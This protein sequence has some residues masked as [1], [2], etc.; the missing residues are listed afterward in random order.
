MGT[1]LG[2][3]ILQEEIGRGAMSVIHRGH[4]PH[5]RRTLAIKVLREEFASRE[6]YR[7][8]FLSEARAAGT[9]THPG[10]VTLF[11]IGESEGVPFI[12][13]E[14]LD[15][16]T[17]DGFVERDGPLPTRMVLRIVMQLADA[18]DYAHRRGVVHQ[19]I[20]PE[21]IAVI[22][23]NGDVKLMDFG[24]ARLRDEATG[25]AS[26]IVAGTPQ[27]MSPEQIRNQRVD[28]RSDLYSLGVLLY[29]LLTGEEPFRADN[30]KELFRKIIDDPLPP[31]RPHDAE[32]PNALRDVVHTL[33]SP[34]PGS[35]YQTGG[36]LIDD[37]RRIDDELAQ[38]ED[39]WSGK[40]IIPIRV[41]WTAIMSVLVALTV[42]L[43]LTV[44]YHKQNGA[45]T[46][47]AQ[48]YGLTLT[49]VLAFESAE[50]LLLKDGVA[51][52]AL[53]EDMASNRDIVYLTISDRQ[54]QVVAGTGAGDEGT[55]LPELPARSL[56][57]RQGEQSIY[58]MDGPDGRAYFLFDAPILY[59]QH[60]IG[61]LRVGL[62]TEALRAANRT[63][64]MAMI[65]LMLVTLA[66]V[67]IGA[68]VLARRFVAPIEILREAL[69]QVARGRYDSRIRLRRDDEFERLYSA[70]NAMADSLE[71]RNQLMQS[72][73]AAPAE[74]RR[75]KSPMQAT[76][77]MDPTPRS[78]A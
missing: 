58:A 33:M 34:D 20:K 35:R 51:L 13:M 22:S 11:D 71:A 44:V 62:S 24:I 1:K 50:D 70:Y 66:T 21:N 31:L 78:K 54:G 19:D 69:N 16:L 57:I 47:L 43:G 45:M 36:E 23:N 8:R 2:R 3:Y 27:Y 49:Q 37:L 15:G 74:G 61:R 72:E 42:T 68:Y 26:D 59:Q 53:V 32:M 65:A 48:D 18:L 6:E 4:D 75:E 28:G 12:A 64:L 38:R 52:R 25:K 14:L 63:T 77:I 73:R 76:C 10:I 67:F 29:W 41:R 40:R 9:L 56:L 17:L 46:R 55:V 7:H 30:I 39:T 5:I 60:A